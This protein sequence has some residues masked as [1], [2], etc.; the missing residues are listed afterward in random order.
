VSPAAKSKGDLQMFVVIEGIEGSGKS[1][2][3]SRLSRGLQSLGYDVVE[4]RE[5]GGTMLGDAV[6]Q[7]FL[8]SSSEVSPLAEALLLNA[9]RAQHVSKIIRPALKS[10]RI[11]LS[12]RFTDSTLAY[13]GYGRGLDLATLRTLSQIATGGLEP[14]LTFVLDAPLRVALDRLPDRSDQLAFFPMVANNPQRA[15]IHSKDRTADRI[16][17]EN[18]DFHERVRQGYLAIAQGSARH[19]LLDASRPAEELG[20]TALR[21][22]R[23][24]LGMRVP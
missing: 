13:Q 17:R 24:K 2:L 1:T 10:Q 14:D 4:T 22:M 16:E 8:K 15:R 11:V 20:E 9:A 19:C 6:R 7:I 18:D 12:D 23:A 21:E 5:P 3:L